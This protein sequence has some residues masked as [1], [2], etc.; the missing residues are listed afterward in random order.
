MDE[1]DG[2][3]RRRSGRLW[4]GDAERSGSCR[5]QGDCGHPEAA[6]DR[7]DV[8]ELTPICSLHYEQTENSARAHLATVKRLKIHF[9]ARSLDLSRHS[10]DLVSF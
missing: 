8:H 4:R 3:S 1:K 2:I 10:A 6:R 7:C 5:D 9:A